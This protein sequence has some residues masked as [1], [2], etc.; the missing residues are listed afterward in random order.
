M[1]LAM[2]QTHDVF[3]SYSSRDRPVVSDLAG[4]LRERGLRV[5]FD[6]WELQPGDS[7]PSRIEAGLEGSAVLVLCL[8]EHSL[9]SDWTALESQTF[10]FRDPLNRDRRFIPV[11]LDDVDL[12]GSLA[13][14]LYVDWRERDEQQLE[15]LIRACEA[16]H[17][18]AAAT[19]V[20]APTSLADGAPARVI[21]LGHTDEV[22][23]VAF[24]PDGA[25]AIS[26]SDDCTV[27]VWDLA[28]GRCERVLEGHTGGVLGV[29]WSPDGASAISASLDC[30]VRVWDLATGSCE[31]VL[32][33]HTGGVWGVAFSPDGARAISASADRTVR[34]WD[35]ATGSC[36]RVLEDHTDRVGGVAWSP[37][38]ARAISASADR[39]V[40]VWDLATGRCERVLEG[41]TDGV[42]GVAWSPDDARAISASLDCTVRVWDL[43]TGRC[44]R[45]L[46]GHTGSVLGVAWSPDGAMVR[47]AA[48]NGVLRVWGVPRA[49][50]EES[51]A[52]GDGQVSYTNAKVVLVGEHQAGKSGLAMRLAHNQW[53]K[54]NS[55]IGAWATQ[56]NVPH[57]GPATRD[58]VEREVWLWDFGGQADQRLIHQL[59]LG[60]TAL[61]VV[62]FDGQK[63]DAVPKLWDWNRALEAAGRA[64]PKILAAGRTD[65]N[66]VRLPASEVDEFCGAAGF[67]KYVET[68]AKDNVGCSEL[69]QAIIELID[70]RQIPWRSAPEVFQRLKGAILDLKDAGRV[71]VSVKELRDWLPSQVGAFEAAE[72][73]AVIGLLA[74]PGAVLPLE[75]GDYV[76]LQPEQLNAY[77]QC[78]IQSL[79][80]DP[81][82]RG[83]IAEER[84]LLG[85]LN[86]HS[87]FQRLAEDEERIVL[88]AMHKQLIEHSICLR[89]IDPDGNRST[90]LVFPSYFRRERPE[91][92]D[93]P[94]AFMSYR[95][96]GYLDEI[97]ASLVVR[98][99]HSERFRPSELWRYSADMQTIDGHELGIRLSIKSDRSGE[100][101]LHCD[102]ETAIKDQ[103]VFAS[104]V[105]QHLETTARAVTPLRTYICP[106]CHTPVENRETARRRL[107]EGKPDIACVSC[108]G[109]IELQDDIEKLLSGDVIRK[110]VEKLRDEA[111]NVLDNESVGRILVA[112][113]MAIIRR[114]G[115][116]EREIL[117]SDVGV[118]MEIEFKDKDGAPTG[119][120]IYLQL[121]AGDSHLRD[122]KRDEQR[123]FQ[124]KHTRHAD[125]WADQPF[126]VLLVVGNS[127]GSIEWMEIREP[128]RRQRASGDW[129][130][131]QIVFEGQRFDVDA[132]LKLR[133][134]A[135]RVTL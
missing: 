49:G 120:K 61:A 125:Y 31:R 56:L 52:G 21:S 8:S 62:V 51:P 35:L 109:R 37:D 43:A 18:L 117:T 104:Y 118:D 98:L 16:P 29:A 99:H 132:V 70:W 133:D 44:E 97:Y 88:L 63:D 15:R 111:K 119:K 79:R 36:E 40:R 135:L 6:E 91:R 89:D 14:F 55:T 4:R 47:S 106:T 20:G 105:Q 116:I 76:L 30:T 24:S 1:I 123:I 115:Q 96:S 82:E 19:G 81:F 127:A 34:V 10:R 46:K 64:F 7:I 113:V 94:Q 75:F 110:A 57:V 122:R 130:A 86:Y 84:V 53:E 9:G 121:K 26:A 25:S 78:V 102:P 41:H 126:L 72:L 95:F 3:L 93:S 90:Q 124:I 13:Q 59:Y 32:E 101:E 28:T 103:A 11:R 48:V 38:G 131:R 42:R 74:G 17:P 73:D 54:T 66:P 2:D 33:G 108:D 39:T 129:P 23:S 71:L 65:T 27:R 83:C 107:L 45:V 112:N 80:D 5:W 128:L 12:K 100:L 69:H 60:E 22:N 50:R 114:A 134:E 68:S 85:E 92:P 58:G 77:A 67:A 87:D